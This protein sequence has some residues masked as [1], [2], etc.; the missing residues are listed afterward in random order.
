[1]TQDETP[2]TGQEPDNEIERRLSALPPTPSFP[3]APKLERVQRPREKT[4]TGM[5]LAQPGGGR[6]LALSMQLA[7]SFTAPVIVLTLGGYLLDHRLHHATPY[8]L[9]GGM[10][11]GLIAGT[12]SAIRIFRSLK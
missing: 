10:L 12:L 3:E 2:P 7:G 4:P 6:N 11:L 1:M 9:L 5:G 8:L